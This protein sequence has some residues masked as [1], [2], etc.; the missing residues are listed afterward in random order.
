VIQ[1]F[2]NVQLREFSG[3]RPSSWS[4]DLSA[5]PRVLT[6]VRSVN[7]TLTCCLPS[8]SQYLCLSVCQYICLCLSVCL[9][10]SLSVCLSVC[11]SVYLSLSACLYHARSQGGVRW[12]QSNPPQP[13]PRPT[14]VA[15]IRTTIVPSRYF[16]LNMNDYFG[17]CPLGGLNNDYIGER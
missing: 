1:R 7:M 2:R 12:V 11:M 4:R 9:S 13:E 16:F 17:V 6:R 8:P 5:S 15:I 14:M 3:R 10:V